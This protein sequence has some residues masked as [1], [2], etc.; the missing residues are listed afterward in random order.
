MRATG[1][2]GSAFATRAIAWRYA[3]SGGWRRETASRWRLISR[4]TVEALRPI[5]SAITRIPI[6]MSNPS[7]MSRRAGSL[8]KRS[9]TS[10]RRWTIGAYVR[11]LPTRLGATPVTARAGAPL[12][13]ENATGGTVR[14]SLRHEV[15][16]S[17]AVLFEPWITGRLRHLTTKRYRP[18]MSDS[19]LHRSLKPA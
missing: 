18:S 16:S 14:E 4:L 10:L 7:A 11:R 1:R 13:A 3:P 12:D 17:R 2:D 8:K 6:P 19:V 9:E 5:V 15:D